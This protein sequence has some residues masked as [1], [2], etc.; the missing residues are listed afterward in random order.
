MSEPLIEGN[1]VVALPFN[2]ADIAA[3]MTRIDRLLGE[4]DEETEDD[5]G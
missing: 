4:D 2:V 3:V 5:E 1:E